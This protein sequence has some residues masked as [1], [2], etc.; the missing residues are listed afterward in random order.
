[1]YFYS[2]HNRYTYNTKNF[3]SFLSITY[4]YRSISIHVEIVEKNDIQKSEIEQLEIFYSK[5]LLEDS[6]VHYER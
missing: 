6:S 1:M 2:I 5:M 4:T 3:T